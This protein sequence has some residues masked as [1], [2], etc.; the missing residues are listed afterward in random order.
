LASKS[1]LAKIKKSKK[2]SSK[3]RTRAT[4]NASSVDDTDD[5]DEMPPPPPKSAKGKGKVP[6]AAGSL[7]PAAASDV[8]PVAGRKQIKFRY[9]NGEV[10]SDVF[11]ATE[12]VRYTGT[13]TNVQQ[14]I[15]MYSDAT[16]KWI[17]LPPGFEPR[18]SLDL[19]AICEVYHLNIGLL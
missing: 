16:G 11:S 15:L 17:P 12:L 5:E 18:I 1:L 2:K 13:P 6:T 3:K 8:A 10:M 9:R 14:N 19:E 4:A 7:A